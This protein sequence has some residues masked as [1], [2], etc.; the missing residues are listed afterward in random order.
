VRRTNT[1][2]TP[3]QVMLRYRDLLRVEQLFRQAKAVLAADSDF[4][5]HTRPL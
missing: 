3:L 1:R 5:G 4:S 2:L